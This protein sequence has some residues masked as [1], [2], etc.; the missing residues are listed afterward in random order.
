MAQRK[1]DGSVASRQFVQ[2]LV[3]VIAAAMMV[4][5]TFR[6]VLSAKALSFDDLQYLAD[7]RLVVSLRDGFR[8]AGLSPRC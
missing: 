4:F 1:G 5:G 8:L 2:F 3:L 6:P 7:N